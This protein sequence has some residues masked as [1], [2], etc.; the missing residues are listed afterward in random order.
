MD[1]FFH[2]SLE[3]LPLLIMM[4]L[5]SSF[6]ELD[7]TLRMIFPDSRLLFPCLLGRHVS[8]ED[9]FHIVSRFL[10]RF[11]GVEQFVPLSSQVLV[12]DVGKLGDYLADYFSVVGDRL[13]VHTEEGLVAGTRDLRLHCL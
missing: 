11:Y 7:L 1:I 4:V 10:L 2:I 13:R 5:T 9:L 8:T 3:T 12:I 6:P